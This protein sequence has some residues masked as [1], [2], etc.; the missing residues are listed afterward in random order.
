MNSEKKDGDRRYNP[1]IEKIINFLKEKDS[2][3]IADYDVDLNSILSKCD[4]LITDYS[5]VVFDYLYLNRPIIFYVPDY[6]EF[7]RNNG[8]EVNVIEKNIGQIAKN[9]DE[10]GTIISELSKN[11]SE[12]FIKLQ[13]MEILRKKIFNPSNN[14]IENIIKIIERT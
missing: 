12:N 13:N 14:G 6:D 2:I 11:N 1:Q 5:G 9:I 8:F 3:I 10:L 4:Y 7:K